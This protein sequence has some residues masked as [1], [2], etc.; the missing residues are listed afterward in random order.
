MDT[1]ATTHGTAAV[2]Q[3]ALLDLQLVPLAADTTNSTTDKTSSQ[4]LGGLYRVSRKGFLGENPEN[5]F[6][7]GGGLSVATNAAEYSQSN[8]TDDF[9]V[10]PGTAAKVQATKDLDTFDV[11]YKGSTGLSANATVGHSL[12]FD[13]GQAMFGFIPRIEAGYEASNPTGVTATSWTK[14][15]KRDVDDDGAHTRAVDTIETTVRTYTNAGA[16]NT[17]NGNVT[18][19]LDTATEITASIVVPVALTVEPGDWPFSFYL[20][21]QPRV[22]MTHTTTK[23]SS[24]VF[25]ESVTTAA[26]DNSTSSVVTTQA[27]TSVES[28]SQEVTWNLSVDQNAGVEVRFGDTVTLLVDIA[29]TFGSGVWDFNNLVVQ[30]VVALP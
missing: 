3:T 25:S 15:I 24:G 28:T 11:V 2:L 30:A 23:T 29:G 20:G 10:T 26:G 22:D 17:V 5:R 9:T 6:F 13:F 7:V 1:N 12:F 8:Q 14:V 18:S 16:I 27:E 19:G 4:D 21:A